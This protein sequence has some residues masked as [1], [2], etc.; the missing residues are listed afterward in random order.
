MIKLIPL[1]LLLTSHSAFAWKHVNELDKNLFLM[2]VQSTVIQNNE[3]IRQAMMDQL[4]E[5]L[6]AKPELITGED[7]TAL[8]QE[9]ES[10]LEKE[11]GH[12]T[13]FVDGFKDYWTEVYRESRMIMR[14]QG[15]GLGI[16]YVVVEAG[17]VLSVLAFTA[18]GNPQMAAVFGAIPFDEIMLW[19]KLSLDRVLKFREN[20]IAYGGKDQFFHFK[21]LHKKVKHAL[22]LRGKKGM[23]IAI[24]ADDDGSLDG[25]SVTGLGKMDRLNKLISLMHPNRHRLDMV[26]LKHFLKKQGLRHDESIVG[27]LDLDAEDPVKIAM[28]ASHLQK[29]HPEAY[30]EL[31][32]QFTK[33]MVDVQAFTLS[34]E[35]QNWSL[36]GLAADTEDEYLQF[37]ASVPAGIRVIDAVKVWTKCLYP[38]VIEESKGLGYRSYR[39]MVKKLRVLEIAAEVNFDQTWSSDW[40]A[41]FTGYFAE[42]FQ[43]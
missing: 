26:T 12:K 33:S 13:R 40:S 17:H 1:I 4:T 10:I 36:M 3:L 15:L 16:A 30:E 23:V 6:V 14:T 27:L 2:K 22:K 19:G 25:V 7:P 37:A 29:N 41:R 35:L 39:S 38:Q 21:Q 31:K 5:R 28:I 32:T 9:L 34:K 20:V 24:A 11:T 43:H 42:A 8:I 18:L